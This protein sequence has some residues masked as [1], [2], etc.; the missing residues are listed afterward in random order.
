MK[1]NEFMFLISVRVRSSSEPS[2]S[3]RDVRV[4]AQRPLLHLRV[5]DPELDDRLAEELQEPLRLVRGADVRRGDDLDEWRAT[6]VEVD[7][8]DVRAA[9]PPG[10]PADVNGLRRVLLEVRAHDPDHAVAIRSW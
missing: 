2:G 9:D 3:D 8:R 1:L 10:P 5:R 6:A 4:D 7:E